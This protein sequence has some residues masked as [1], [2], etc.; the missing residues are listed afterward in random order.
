M[1]ILFII[2]ILK[3]TFLISNFKINTNTE[4]RSKC[5]NDI[6]KRGIK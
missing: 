2:C 5:Y 4:K 3:K 6:I 1:H